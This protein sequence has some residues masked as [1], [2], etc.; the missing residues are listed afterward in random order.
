[1]A[2]SSTVLI[3]ELVSI[4]RGRKILLVGPSLPFQGAAWGGRLAMET[5]WYP[6]NSTEATQQVLG[7]Q[8]TSSSWEGVFRRTMMGKTPSSYTDENG[9]TVKVTS[10]VFMRDVLELL[11]QLGA[12]LRVT[13]TQIRETDGRKFEIVREGRA[14]SWEFPHDRIE[15]ISWRI[16]FVWVSRG[17]D[18]QKAVSVRDADIS[19]SFVQLDAFM[20]ELQAKVQTDR[21]KQ[22]T[23]GVLNSAG[24][25]TLGQ[26]EALAKAPNDALKS[27]TDSLQRNI[28]SIR[29]A[30][31]VADRFRSA[32]S[33]ITGTVLSFTQNNIALINQYVDKWSRAPAESQTNKAKVADI[34]RSVT[35]FGQSAESM[36]EL[37][38]QSQQTATD[39]AKQE[40][41]SNS[42]GASVPSSQT[43]K[44]RP[45]T[46]LAVHIFKQGETIQN[47]SLKYYGTA[48]N[49]ADILKANRLPINTVSVNPGKIL[50]I[51]VLGVGVTSS[52]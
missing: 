20:N 48:D 38:R 2:D 23:P 21:L 41:V 5:V 28:N 44:N 4:G 25:L 50:I 17:V 34:T 16:S 47:V 51:P 3:E 11:F 45:G 46:I 30:V 29:R 14:E 43:S 35:Y 18:Q 26:L 10:P 15:D 9:S 32:P 33:Q 7:P 39:L 37:A 1:M 27:V 22:T 19:A 12:R 52:L 31:D 24:K 8:L 40:S 13:W 36:R 42:R 6:G 49:V